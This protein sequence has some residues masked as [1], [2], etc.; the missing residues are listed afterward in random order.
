MYTLAID[1]YTMVFELYYPVEIDK[2]SIDIDVVI[3][4]YCK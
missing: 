2:N 3:N 4:Q 1:F